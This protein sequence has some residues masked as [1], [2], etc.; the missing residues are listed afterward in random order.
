LAAVRFSGIANLTGGS[1]P[2]AFL[3]QGSAGGF[4]T[5]SGGGGANTLDYSGYTAGPVTLS[6]GPSPSTGI[7]AV[8]YMSTVV[9]S[10]DA[11]DTL[12][13]GDAA[14]F[15]TITGLN[16]G[17]G[18]ARFS[19]FENLT[20]GTGNDSFTL[21]TGGGLSGVLTGGGGT[22]TV[23]GPNSASPTAWTLDG[24]NTGTVGGGGLTSAAVRFKGIANLTGGTGNDTF[25][26]GT[27]GT[28]S[29]N[30]TGGGGSDAL[31][32][33]AYA[34]GVTVNLASTA[35]GAAAAI[36]GKVSGIRVVL[37][38]SGNDALTAG[39]SGATLVGGAGDD[40]LRGGLGNDVLIGGAGADTLTAGSARSLL[41]GGSGADTMT[42]G[43]ADDLL[44]SGTTSYYNEGTGAVNAV[45]FNA[46]LKEWIRTDRDF[47]GRVTDLSNGVTGSDANP[48]R[49]GATTLVDDGVADQL[50]RG[51]GGLDWFLVGAADAVTG[52]TASDRVTVL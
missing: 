5:V 33:S 22:D 14:Y 17:T 2:D 45:A 21:A 9:G 48:Y 12:I 7:H 47:G 46:L 50:F 28:L 8:S 15:W 51:S 24:S 31:D 19:G 52:A 20:G 43:G 25:A 30:V 34:T 10:G 35:A 23:V 27:A 26:M 4:G 6:L 13:G 1:G 18:P 39:T 3:M 42:G 49:L 29:G 36:A 11:H 16:S 40:S 32:Y 37:G 41:V 38:G 44:I